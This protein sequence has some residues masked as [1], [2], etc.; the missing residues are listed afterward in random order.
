MLNQTSILKPL[1]SGA[2]KKW[3]KDSNQAYFETQIYKFSDFSLFYEGFR[4]YLR[5]NII[6]N[7]KCSKLLILGAPGAPQAIGGPQGPPTD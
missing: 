6:R 1:P 5:S 3:I 2:M 7:Y 4:P